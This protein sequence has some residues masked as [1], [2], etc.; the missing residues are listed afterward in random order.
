MKHAM[1]KIKELI[2][3]E[4]I[5]H[6]NKHFLK[7]G[8][9][10]CTIDNRLYPEWH[11]LE[12]MIVEKGKYSLEAWVVIKGNKTHKMFTNEGLFPYRCIKK[13][14]KTQKEREWIAEMNVEE[15]L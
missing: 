7:V 6:W 4:F 12:G 2:C 5:H 15:S 13:I 11:K 8:D 3:V 1:R 14:K 10:F 9:F